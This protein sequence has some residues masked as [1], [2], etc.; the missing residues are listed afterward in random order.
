[1]K[2]RSMHTLY[3]NR[4][5]DRSWPMIHRDACRGILIQ[6]GLLAMIHSEVDGDYKFPGGGVEAE[7]SMLEALS[8]EVLEES[9]IRIGDPI[10]PYVVVEEIGGSRYESQTIYRMHSHYYLAA[11]YQ[12]GFRQNL[13][14]YEEVAQYRLT[15][16]SVEEALSHNRALLN[17]VDAMPWLPREIYVLEMLLQDA[18]L[19]LNTNIR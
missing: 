14:D 3:R 19:P 13:D 1:M 2:P 8:R 18:S 9:G 6:D 17:R 4:D 5:Y 15:F 7:E 11:I 10:E 12:K 16:V